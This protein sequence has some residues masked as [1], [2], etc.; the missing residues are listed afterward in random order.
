M[1]EQELGEPQDVDPAELRLGP[2]PHE[3]LPPNLLEAIEA[4]YGIVGPY[5]DTSLEQFEIGFMR[6]MH[7]KREVAVWCGIASAWR[8][9]HAQHLGGE[10]LPDDEERKLLGALIAVSIGVDDPERLGVPSEVGRRLL[11]CHHE[12]AES[13]SPE[14]E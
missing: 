4:V 14:E 7:P 1:S 13:A 8:A 5:L 3:S 6:D 11:K 10:S 9:Y 2:I 12:P